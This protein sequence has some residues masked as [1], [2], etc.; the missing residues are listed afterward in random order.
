MCYFWAIWSIQ[1]YAKRVS[2]KECYEKYGKTIEKDILSF[3]LDEK[4]ENLKINVNG[5]LYSGD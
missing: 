2:E 4:H 3:I 5:L 1:Q